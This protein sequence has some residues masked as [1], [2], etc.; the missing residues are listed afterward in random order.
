MLKA[1]QDD[2]V[3]LGR[4]AVD[5]LIRNR[6]SHSFFQGQILWTGFPIKFIEYRRMD[7]ETGKSRWTFGK[8][9]TYL[10]D[11]VIGYSYFPIRF[12][13]IAGVVIAVLGL[14]YAASIFV[15]KLI[16]GIPVQGWAP[17]MIMILVMGGFQMLMLGIIG[18][19]LWRA[20]AQVRNRD[21][22]IVDTVYEGPT[23]AA[24]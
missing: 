3:L 16:G 24:R 2:F 11:G 12:I 6:E 8:K 19:Y 9:L 22:Y 7:R 20:L 15:L 17:L 18:E 21:L 4:K 23:D 10:L 1:P 5:V 13:A 14:L